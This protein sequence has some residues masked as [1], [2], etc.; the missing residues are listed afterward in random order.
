MS[1]KEHDPT[2]YRP[3]SEKA[4][5]EAAP[6]AADRLNLLNI[7]LPKVH[8]AANNVNTVISKTSPEQVSGFMA[9]NAVAQAPVAAMPT[10]ADSG[11]NFFGDDSPLAYATY[12]PSENIINHN[13]ELE[14]AEQARQMATAAM[15]QQ[16]PAPNYAPPLA[17]EYDVTEATEYGPQVGDNVRF[18][19]ELRN[20]L[21][22]D[23]VQQYQQ[24]SQPMAAVTDIASRQPLSAADNPL[25]QA[26]QARDTLA[27]LYDNQ[28]RAA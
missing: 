11:S 10:K 4:S 12:K 22:A 8:A 20:D 21:A 16:Q 13:D 27:E 18:I 5:R 9:T 1:N 28:G 19:H 24:P 3:V 25:L 23:T 6:A 17:A 7:V 2:E 26:Q 15:A 14:R